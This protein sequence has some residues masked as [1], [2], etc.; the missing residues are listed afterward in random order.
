MIFGQFHIGGNAIHTHN[1]SYI[2]S[3]I[4]TISARRPFLGAGCM[5]ATLITGF[6]VSFFDLLYPAELAGIFMG[7]GACL[8]LGFWLGQLQL[9]SRDLRGSELGTAIWGSYSHLN[10]IRRQVAD[11]VN[12]VHFGNE[13]KEDRT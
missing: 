13:N 5:I 7:V 2:L 11:V 9:L 10:R 4:T 8:F 3:N 12:R 6:G 1:D